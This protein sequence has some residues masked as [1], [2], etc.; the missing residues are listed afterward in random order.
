MQRE[1]RR[2]PLDTCITAGWAASWADMSAEHNKATV[3]RVLDDVVNGGDL[4]AIAELYRPDFVDHEPLP[5]APPGIEGV[6]YSI[7][8]LRS[9]MP[10]LRVVIEDISA[11]DDK[12][13][14]HT[15]WR[16][17]QH[18]KLMGISGGGREVVTQAIVIWRLVDG[19]IAERWALVSRRPRRSS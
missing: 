13:V 6:R 1:T 17:K 5:G 19:R 11:H 15:T 16:G 18:G 8:G 9:A 12:V 2:V 14:V 3:R 4:D 10:D 7:A